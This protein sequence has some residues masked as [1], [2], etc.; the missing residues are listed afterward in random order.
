[1]GSLILCSELVLSGATLTDLLQ[2]C[3][4][5]ISSVSVLTNSQ[6]RLPPPVAV[7]V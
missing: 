3:T 7:A 2:T 1:M 4:L 6:V 5:D